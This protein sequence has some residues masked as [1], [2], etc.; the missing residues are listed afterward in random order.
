MF[1]FK[2]IYLLSGK[3]DIFILK[4]KTYHIEFSPA[5]IGPLSNIYTMAF[6][7]L[8]NRLLTLTTFKVSRSFSSPAY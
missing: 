5:S 4:D 7:F 8:N 6:P 2:Y 3:A 1:L